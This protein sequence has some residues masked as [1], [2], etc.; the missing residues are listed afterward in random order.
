MLTAV[1]TSGSRV[2]APQTAISPAP[3]FFR[4]SIRPLLSAPYHTPPRQKVKGDFPLF[5]REVQS[6]CPLGKE[7]KKPRPPQRESPR[8]F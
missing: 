4:R 8:L 1:T 2:S 7:A 6:P 5:W 3:N